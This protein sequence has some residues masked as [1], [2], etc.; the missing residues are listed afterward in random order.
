MSYATGIADAI[1]R[2]GDAQSRG[3]LQRGQI[4]GNLAHDLG[5]A[6]LNYLAIQRGVNENKHRE[7]VQG[8]QERKIKNDQEL[9][10]LL[11]QTPGP[12][13]M[14][15]SMEFWQQRDPEKYHEAWQW[16]T[17]AAQAQFQ[18]TQGTPGTEPAMSRDPVS[19]E[20]AN[21]D[22][23]LRHAPIEFPTYGGG[24]PQMRTPLTD[25]QMATRSNEQLGIVEQIK[26]KIRQQE[27]A[28]KPIIAPADATVMMPGQ[29]PYQTPGRQIQ[30]KED[31]SMSP[32]KLFNQ[33]P[34]KYGAMKEI[35]AKASAKYRREPAPATV[36][37]V[38]RDT[39]GNDV[40]RVL[41][42]AEA[43]K[44]SE[45][46]G[47]ISRAAPAMT[48]NRITAAENSIS[49]GDR[50]LKYLE[51]P[52]V[53]A[54]L[55]PA[56]GRVTGWQNLIGNPPPELTE[57]SGMLKSWSE[58]QPA[59]HGMRS[60]EMAEDIERGAPTRMTPEAL[61][62]YIRGFQHTARTVA[63]S[64]KPKTGV[65]TSNAPPPGTSRIVQQNKKTGAYR[66]SE[67]GGKTWQPGQ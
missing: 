12:D 36:T 2:M 59:V 14:R 61:A 21:V 65:D 43:L 25:V 63:N 45:G 60:S 13:K 56:M 19:G 38:T 54:G 42:K 40:T 8:E 32:T 17:Q 57:L 48:R 47:G 58:L 10:A 55:G 51:D 66:H 44:L 37:I 35:E 53:K 52:K 9:V 30:P 5:Q 62:G 26:S 24:A 64:E 16:M 29:A 49:M 23:Q 34:A 20:M 15:V 46:G 27:Q 28:G 33:D 4:Y 67:D 1:A 41:T 11:A 6:P 39:E 31:T 18:A 22:N 50:V 3:A 7:V